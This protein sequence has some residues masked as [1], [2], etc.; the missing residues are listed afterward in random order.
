M[1]INKQVSKESVIS[2]LCEAKRRGWRGAKFYFLIGLP[3]TGYLRNNSPAQNASEPAATEEEE[4]INFIEEAARKTG[5]HFNINI[6]TFVPKPH[7]PFQRAKQLNREE[8]EKKLSQL[9]NR[10]KTK[11][12]KVGVQDPL[13]SAIEGLLSRGDKRAGEVFEE[14]F[15]LGCRLD[16]WNE[17]FKR[18]IWESILIKHENLLNEFLNGKEQNSNLPWAFINSKVSDYFFL[19]ENEKSKS[20]EITL[21]CTN[22]CNNSCGICT[23][24][25]N[26]GQNNIHYDVNATIKSE[27]LNTKKTDPPTHR[28][29]FS[30]SKQASAVFHPHL[31]LIE[32]FS[33][34]FIRAGIPLLYSCGFNPLPKLEIAS[35]LSLGIK[36]REEIALID[37]KEFFK[38]ENF[39]ERI[40]SC[41]P[42]G[43]KIMNVMNVYIRQGGKKHSL[44]SLL[45]G[46]IYNG[47]DGNPVAVNAKEEKVY[48][49]LRIKEGESIFNFERLSLLACSGVNGEKSTETKYA[50][51]FDV[52]RN[53]Y[54]DGG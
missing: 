42:D 5:M 44:S 53:L 25:I 21:K 45:W 24:S 41:L 48:R 14:A 11:G 17:Y 31:A 8:A 30:F 13:V 10:L 27:N 18:E 36:A 15:K 54:P 26:I 49:N 32:I 38:A 2:I 20:M 51:Y 52:Y 3:L 34:A 23:N 43:F 22:N 9:R 37:T 28:I 1:V 40:N 29:I 35:P 50:S 39:I 12:H 4:I 16:S 33:M 6:G 7:T 46:F 47:K 19:K